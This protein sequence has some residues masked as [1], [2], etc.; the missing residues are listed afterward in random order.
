[1]WGSIAGG[2]VSG[3]VS[4]VI[5]GGASS[6]ITQGITSGYGNIVVKDVIKDAAI[7]GF[8]GGAI[9]G[10]MAWAGWSSLK[11]GKTKFVNRDVKNFNGPG[12]KWFFGNKNNLTLFKYGTRFRIEMSLVHGLHVHAFTDAAKWKPVTIAI[13]WISGTIGALINRLTD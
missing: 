7:S 4:G 6:I 13:G 8:L 11:L 9:G 10:T 12:A 2:A 3:A 5:I 1:M